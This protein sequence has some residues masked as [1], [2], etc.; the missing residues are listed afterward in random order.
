MRGRKKGHALHP[1]R[2]WSKEEKI[3]IVKRCLNLDDSC[4]EISKQEK[5][6]PGQLY[7]WIQKFK[8][9]GEVG[10][11]RIYK[12]KMPYK[13][14]GMSHEEELELENMKLKIELE[15]AKKGYI[16]KGDGQIVT[17]NTL[18]K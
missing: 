6:N 7:A 9:E 11:E 3:R 10:F 17:F 5:I 12:R 4:N 15:F 14:K 16:M 13:R 1:N 18:G 8:N 2:F